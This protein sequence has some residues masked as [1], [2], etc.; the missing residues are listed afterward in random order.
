MLTLTSCFKM[1]DWKQSLTHQ[2]RAQ[3]FAMLAQS[4]GCAQ[5]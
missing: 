4:L 5:K 2:P 3:Y 1:A